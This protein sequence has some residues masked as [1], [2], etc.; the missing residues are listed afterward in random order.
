M[1]AKNYANYFGGLVATYRKVGKKW[2]VEVNRK[3][4]YKSQNFQTKNDAMLWAIEFE[5]VIDDAGG[6]YVPG[7][8]LSDCFDRYAKEVSPGKKGE[9]WEVVRLK[10]LGRSSLGPIVV[11]DLKLTDVERWRDESLKT[12]SPAS[13]NRELNLL[14]SVVKRAVKWRWVSTYPLAGIERPKNPPSRSRRITAEEEA[15]ILAEL[16]IDP[17]DIRAFKKKHQVGILFLLAI[18]TAARLGELSS[19]RWENVNLSRRFIHLPSTK[20]GESRN[21]PLSRRAV[22]ILSSITPARSGKVFTVSSGTASTLFR[23]Y[24]DKAGVEGLH[25]HDTRHEGVSRLAKVKGMD[26]MKL[27]KIV[28]HRDPR[29]LMTYFDPTVEELAD[30]L[31]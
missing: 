27:A 25:F 10:K 23:R 16:D 19:L 29:S 30:L 13:V 28:G 14:I 2:R 5:K 21:V 6:E 7:Y 1:Y 9:R 17:N 12:I 22:Y 3:G 15:A 31:D 11:S 24:R 20:N 8:C 26:M 18:E 4:V